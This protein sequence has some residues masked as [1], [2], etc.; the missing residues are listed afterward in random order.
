MK[1]MSDLDCSAAL[2]ISFGTSSSFCT[3][4]TTHWISLIMLCLLQIGWHLEM[5]SCSSS[6]FVTRSLGSITRITRSSRSLTYGS[7]VSMIRVPMLLVIS[8][9]TPTTLISLFR[10]GDSSFSIKASLG[11]K[12]VLASSTTREAKRTLRRLLNSCPALCTAWTWWAT[13]PKSGRVCPAA[14]SALSS[15]FQTSGLGAPNLNGAGG[16][17]SVP[18][19]VTMVPTR[20]TP[21]S[22][23]DSRR[24]LAPS[25]AM[26]ANF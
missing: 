9:A 26:N 8:M 16:G 5:S 12:R 22:P 7:S 10:S 20:L 2:T 4:L 14:Y 18:S 11:L 19:L 6:T 15:L 23:R 3:C 17:E 1:I 24:L 25:G 21:V 13:S